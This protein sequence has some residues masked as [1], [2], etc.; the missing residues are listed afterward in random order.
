MNIAKKIAG[1]LGT[2]IGTLYSF[3]PT[4]CFASAAYQDIVEEDTIAAIYW[5]LLGIFL[6]LT[7]ILA[8]KP[9]I[10]LNVINNTG[11]TVNVS[12]GEAA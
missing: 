4:I 5:I 2:A 12:G 7:L 3:M 6:L 10:N 8:K 11:H 9:V 1:W